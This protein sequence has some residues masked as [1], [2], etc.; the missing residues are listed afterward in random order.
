MGQQELL[1]WRLFFE[2]L[3]SQAADPKRTAFKASAAAAYPEELWEAFTRMASQ[4]KLQVPTVHKR[5]FSAQS[6]NSLVTEGFGLHL[7]E[8]NQSE[9]RAAAMLYS[10]T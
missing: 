1:H 7:P 3:L 2:H 6:I 10:Q 8:L 9:K 4:H 5:M